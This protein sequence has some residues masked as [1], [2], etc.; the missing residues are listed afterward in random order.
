VVI[1][2]MKKVNQNKFNTIVRQSVIHV[3]GMI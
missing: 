2:S 3:V 1:C